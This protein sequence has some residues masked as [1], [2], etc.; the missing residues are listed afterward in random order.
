MNYCLSLCVDQTCIIN[1][2]KGKQTP[3]LGETA[4]MVS[5]PLDLFSLI[6]KF[7]IKKDNY[8]NLLMSRLY[9]GN[10][11]FSNLSIVGPFIGAP[12]ATILLENLI[13]SGVKKVIFLGWCGAVSSDVKIGEIVIPT[14]ALIE[15][16]TSKHYFSISNENCI[17][18]ASSSL[19]KKIESVLSE[20]KIHYHKGRIWTTDAIFRETKEKVSI[21]M[22]KGI[23]AVEME[24]SAIFS[25]GKFRGIETCGLLTV[26]DELSSLKWK[27]GFS[28]KKFKKIRSEVLSLMVELV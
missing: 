28:D 22:K 20:K 24:L 13:V 12:F 16:G 7:G 18:D 14:S 19:T 10:G 5:N 1:P 15:E 23:L 11:K 4:I 25:V 21:F 27:P 2:I 9:K 6:S 17:I 8:Y 3:K 26:S